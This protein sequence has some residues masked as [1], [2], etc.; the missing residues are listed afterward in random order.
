[1]TLE[2][3]LLVAVVLVVDAVAAV[4]VVRDDGLLADVELLG[5]VAVGAAP[6]HDH[7]EHAGEDQVLE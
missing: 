7:G 5:P 3:K 2:G 4:V 1:M 6:H